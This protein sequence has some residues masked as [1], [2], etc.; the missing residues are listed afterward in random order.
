MGTVWAPAL[1]LAESVSVETPLTSAGSLKEAVTPLGRP[2]TDR[3]TDT[4]PNEVTRTVTTVLPEIMAKLLPSVFTLKSINVEA[5]A[6]QA[7]AAEVAG[8]SQFDVVSVPT[9]FCQ[10]ARLTSLPP[11]ILN[12]LEVFGSC[13]W[14]LLAVRVLAKPDQ[15]LPLK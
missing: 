7:T 14:L 10:P 13:Q 12:E 1:L 11:D 4:K 5:G 9:A 3:F 8:A 15:S 2:V 6:A